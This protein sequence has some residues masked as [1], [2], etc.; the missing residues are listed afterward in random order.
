MRHDQDDRSIAVIGLACRLPGAGS[1]AAFWQV[2]RDGVDAVTEVPD[3]RWPAGDEPFAGAR[4]GGFLDQVDGFDAGFFGISPR[5][6]AAM[7]PQQRLVLELGWEVLE[8]AGIAPDRIAGRRTGVFVG[9]IGDDYATL[10]LRG[11][12]PIVG[13]H[14]FT[15][16]QRSMIA[17]RLSYRLG[18]HGP[19]LVVD[20]GQSSSLAAVH[21]ACESLRS[22]AA[23]LAIAGGVNLNLVSDTSVSLSRLGALSPDGRCHTFDAR[24]N[25]YV[26]GEGGG[27]VLLKPLSA[28]VADG[29]RVYCVIRGSAVNNDGGGDALTTPS[30]AAQEDVLRQAYAAAGI[31]AAAVQYVELHGTGTPVGDPIEAGALGA[32]LG[33]ARP[34]ARP[35]LVGSA[36]TNV[37]HLE[38]AAGITGLIKVALALR[39]GEL[40]PSL[41]FVTPNPAIAFDDWNLRVQHQLSAWPRPDTPLVAGVSSFGVGGT[42]VHVVLERTSIDSSTVDDEPAGV[43]PG[44]VPWVVS[45]TSAEGLRGQAARLRE[46]VAESVAGISNIGWSLASSRAALGHRAV[47]V[48]EDR[49]DLLNGLDAIAA[50]EPYPNVVTAAASADQVVFVFPGQG[51]Q[52]VGMGAELLASSPVFAESVAECADVLAPY[53]AW[54]LVDVLRGNE[55]A[56]SL[57]RVEVLQ[58]V[59]WTMMVSLARMWRSLGIE[60]AL[61]VGHSQGEIAAACVAGALSLADGARLV[62]GRSA[63]VASEL[64]GEGGML[65][66]GATTARVEELLAGRDGV[67]VA[68]TNGPFDTV[69]AGGPGELDEMAAT[70]E[71]V[72][73]RARRVAVDYAS[74]T[75]HMERL[76]E[77]LLDLARPVVPRS[78]AV[79][80]YS[81]VTAALV[82]GETLD[83]EYWYRNLREPVRLHET[84]QAVLDAGHTLFLEVSA[85]P[86]VTGAI[87]ET[88]AAQGID[89]TAVGTLRRDDAS[90]TRITM[91]LAELWA[92]GLTPDWGTVF[93]GAKRVDLPTYAFQ[94]ARHWLDGAEPVSYEAPPEPQRATEV[95]APAAP[96]ADVA[97]VVRTQVAAV[98]G[99]QSTADIDT[100][101]TFKELGF[102]SFTLGVL[103]TRLNKTLS[104]ALSTAALFDHPT[105]GKLAEY[106]APANPSA[107]AA[108]RTN[109]A[110]EPIAIIGMS[111]RFPGGVRS[112]EDLWRLVASEGDAISELPADRGWDLDRLYATDGPGTT[113]VRGGGF[114]DGVAEFDPRFFGLS[115]REALAMDPQQRLLLELAWELFERAGIDSESLRDSRTGVFVG[116]MDQEYG[117][118]LHEA[119]AGVDGFLLTGKTTS[120]ASGRIAYLF[121]LTGPAMT[122]DTA[123]SSSLVALHQAVRSLRQGES[124]LALAG[125]VTVL[126]TPGVITELSRQGGLAL[127][128]RSKAF[129]AAADGMGAAE[130]AGLLLVERLSDAVRNGHEVLAVVRGS[131]VNQDGASNGLTAPNGLSQQQVILL[132]LADARLEPSDVD[133]VEAHGTG[134]RL[135][136]PIEARA[137][138][139]TYGQD[140]PADR[141][142]L[143][144]SV[145]SNIGHTQAA[146][147]VAGVIKTVMAMRHGVVPATLHIDEPTAEVDWAEGAVELATSG[148]PWP[149]RDGVRRAGV[150]SFGISG[151]NAHLVLEHTPT[152]PPPVQPEEP[153]GV[154]PWAVSGHSAAGLRAQAACLRD[155]AAGTVA[156]IG[157]SLVSTRTGH[158]HRAVVLAEDRAGFAAGL[159]ALASGTPSPD[160]VSGVRSADQR[161]VF[162]FPGQGSQWAGMA[163]GLLASSPVFA[164][165]I[166]ECAAALAPHVD[167][168]LLDVLRTGDFERVDV[169]QP[170]LW[171]VM[172][173][174]AKLWRSMGVEPSAVVGHSQGEIAAACVAGALSLEDGAR[175]VALRSKVIAGELAGLGG[176]VSIAASVERV[177]ELLTGDDVHVAVVNGPSSTVVAGPPEGLAVVL[178]AAERAGLR[179]KTVPVD[180]ASHTPQVSEVR[181]VLLE[182]AAPI[183]PQRSQVPMYSTV[184]A[185]EID[186]Q[187]ALDAE[188]WYRNLRERVRF[189]D[190]VTSLLAA[191]HTVFLEVSPHPV[192]TTA[193]DETAHAVDRDVLAT[194]TLRRDH[195]GTAHLY[196]SLVELWVR[197]V[198]PDWSAVFPGARRVDLPTYAFQRERYWLTGSSGGT[199]EAS[200]EMPAAE[201]PDGLPGQ[202]AAAGARAQQHR[203]VLDAV[204]GYTAVVLGWSTSGEVEVGRAFRECGVDSLTAVE[205]RKHLAAA[206]GLALSP[207]VVFDYP[208]PEALAEYVLARLLGEESGDDQVAVRPDAGEPIA[209]VAASCRFPGGVAS[210]EEL[211][212]LLLSDRDPNTGFPVDR[213]WDLAQLHHSDQGR[214]G[215]CSVRSSGFLHDAA[216]FDAGFFG[217]SPREAT[218]M[219]PQQRLLLET[220]WETF[221]RAGIDPDSLRGSRTGVFAGV[222][223][224][225]YG[226]GANDVGDVE[227]YVFTGATGSV[228]SGRIAYT[229]GLT[230]PA[231]TVDT[232][233]SSSLVALHMAVRSLR[234]GECDL[235]LAGGVTVIST[236]R[237]FSDFSKQGALAPDG[238]CKPFAAAADGTAWSEGIG[239][240]LVERLS[241]ARRNGHQVLAVVR[242]S[243]INQD[244]ASNGLTAPNGPAQQRVIRLALA[245]AGLQPS[246]VDVVEAHGTGTS[247]GDPVE[248][249]ALLATYGQGRPTD[250]PLLLGS[251]KSVIG[252][253]S[254]AAGVAGVITMVMAMRAGTVPGTRHVDRPTPHVDW[255]SG[256]VEL[257]T[258]STP[259]PETGRVRRSSVSSFG[260]SGTNAHLILEQAPEEDSSPEPASVA[261]RSETLPWVLSGQ[262]PAGLK[263]QA[264]RL[265]RFAADAE[266]DVADIGWSLVSARAGLEHR[267][268]VLADD[269]AAFLAGLDAF[270][271]GAPA[272]QVVT[273][274]SANR[275]RVVF[276]FPGQ[277]SQWAGMA[278][279]LLASSPVFADAIAACAEALAPHVDWDLLDVLR[280][281]AFERVD[282]VQPALWAVMV[283]LATLWRSVGVE[284][285]AVVGHSQGEIAAACVAGALSLE[286]GARLVALR[287]KV[288]AGELAG[289]GGMVSIAASAERVRGLLAREDAWIAAVNGP[290]ST[291]VAGT[292]DA[293]AATIAAC[294][295]QGLRAKVIPVDYASHTPHVERV[296]TALLDLAAPFTPATGDVPMYSTVTVG[297]IDTAG[298][299]AEYWYR[300]L[301][302]RVRF[303]EVAEVL[304]DEGD[305]VFLEVS[306]HPVLSTAI[307]EAAHARDVETA[308]VGTLRR[309]VNGPTRFVTSMAELWAHGVGVDW[310][311]V[312]PSR[313]RVNLPTY[314][315]QRERHWLE[316]APRTSGTALDG[317]FWDLVERS[318][319]AD[320]ATT[321]QLDEQASLPE[322][323][324]ALSA[325]HRA[326]AERF[327]I[328]ALRY[329][330]DWKPLPHLD[331]G[332]LAGTWLVVGEDTERTRV[333]VAGLRALGVDVVQ[334]GPDECSGHPT[335]TGV[336]SLLDGVGATLKVL[337]AGLNA[338]LWCVTQGAVTAGGDPVTSPT[339]AQVWGLGRV[340]AQEM[341]NTWGGLIDLPAEMGAR[342]VER[343]CATLAAATEDQVAI[344]ASGVF[345]RRLVHAPLGDRAEKWADGWTAGRGT[346]LITG[347]TGALGGHIARKLATLGAEHLLLVSRQGGDAAGAAQLHDELTTAGVAVTVAAC[348]VADPAAL[349]DLV[350]AIPTEYPLTAVVH[351]AAVLD[352]AA[353]TALTPERMDHVLRVKAGAAWRLH[354]LTEHLDLTAF[355][356]VSSV[357][358]TVGMGGQGNYAPGNAYL[359]AL[360]EYRR[361]RKLVATSIAWGTWA[362]GMAEQDE[363]TATRR[364]HGIPPMAPE[365]ATAALE[366]ALA[367]DDTA[368]VVADVDWS[369]FAHA[370]TAAR[371]G[372][373]LD[374]LPEARAAL[375]EATQQSGESLRD[376]LAGLPA[377]DRDRELRDAVRAQVAAVLGYDSAA[378]ISNRR[379]LPEFGMDSVTAV[380]LCNRLGS[381]TALRLPPTAV[382]DYPTVAELADHLGTRLFGEVSPAPGA[383]ELDALGKVLADLP[384]DDP[385]RAG[386]A[387][388]LR[389]LVR[390]AAPEQLDTASDEEIFGFIEQEF[391]IS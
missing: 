250:R 187:D 142:A 5:E 82:A 162:V 221:E 382:F 314:A 266:A 384:A 259:W 198:V 258:G 219:D 358:G 166:G 43:L 86:M 294:D 202:V 227:G 45:G 347:G 119:P 337:Q 110:D 243:A 87:E 280:T 363:V 310:G 122:I 238:H 64:S 224:H 295:A 101:R 158:D 79:M 98:L 356:M 376:R 336:L 175:L 37:G 120:V 274:S 111:C 244:G 369:R 256:A 289:L 192:L 381:V 234:Q 17:N 49:T 228:A 200:V 14:T 165:A 301:R 184:T 391:G 25:G 235:A 261:L 38:G 364:R 163:T 114:L 353:V 46:F 84:V 176:M 13:H 339:Q 149:A 389:H 199:S 92:H 346:V 212:G 282:V 127:D 130:G 383:A 351:A 281:G 194:G 156:D 208:T 340:A 121:G 357:A 203:I 283:S 365:R 102:D 284:P 230:G 26:R 385:A 333:V 57:E 312:F 218:A 213:G 275:A 263:A 380:E 24:A 287:S 386:I 370:Y 205:L 216:D 305:V 343:L 222:V 177:R 387:D 116:T 270:A 269:C 73:L 247:L 48:A 136:D 147:G 359:D 388:R 286:D 272:P 191:G 292:P 78:G 28:A 29:N 155:G 260:V 318:S 115:A 150:S 306:P 2:L 105:P 197:G 53:L 204:C 146:A 246:D 104:T 273:G 23:D 7:D 178:A 201:V 355:V 31:D 378:A 85:H 332:A 160:V 309:D 65:W 257:A 19:S 265:R 341:P 11:T 67:W 231:I 354:E 167:W 338:P 320:L 113:P 240:V 69:V 279:D 232:A 63:V 291:V 97:H 140:R 360:A 316:P 248:A 131:A 372:P 206:T 144:G 390:T 326:R 210:P 293:M 96:E 300:N 137:L 100:R 35:L 207:T 215:T 133:V 322:V 237:V 220:S 241:D 317:D 22:G 132:A 327:T 302:E 371:R 33:G 323:L 236:P 56:A 81:T 77:Q 117:P 36:K 171:A 71:Q 125:G 255:T 245:D 225:G 89:A 128:G 4:R 251:A 271:S 262:T 352:D 379:R 154:L 189:H 188:Y 16:L 75:P 1:P 18:T 134:T 276:V 185:A 182:L 330:V 68:A 374:E 297:P 233:C 290:V 190:T 66:I 124:T 157:W 342:V 152:D 20:T 328:D 106:L 145:K 12:K 299:D 278:T 60:P 183:R 40:P 174:L 59:L 138:L 21:L 313:G 173:S 62:A 348:D 91:S 164:E 296:R 307:L 109:P 61:V 373:L 285:S 303:H 288:I 70:C 321:L 80:M 44:P 214:P 254:A 377:R 253:S 368:V 95:A 55:N 229:F 181:A 249:Q 3:G 51:S 334:A 325:W 153:T 15:G 242:G 375:A 112:Q 42:N 217:I 107:S 186:T 90:A 41:N 93:P 161:V 27:L 58:P 311:R 143:L 6:A 47:V 196:R 139:A 223:A 304:L 170:A 252:H 277:G 298:L 349:T 50:G 129:A 168:D 211:L 39:A 52:W 308:V 344:R 366:A 350:A 135:G 179:A 108:V 180:Y 54:D 148:T 193:V 74:H 151:T 335:V 83:A 315:F 94:R 99:Y 239:M 9:A 169:V 72:G 361:A 209:I 268:V 367:Y 345:G 88:A 32:V 331:S 267:A 226:S 362:D 319:L 264:V 34:Q 76:R 8:D 141:P 118:R 159:D 324:P 103:R 172:V 123:C 195:G 329:R 30:Q 126:S 10:V